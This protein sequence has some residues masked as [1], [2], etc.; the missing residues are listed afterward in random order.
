MTRFRSKAIGL[1]VTGFVAGTLGVA[2][3]QEKGEAPLHESS[4]EDEWA[5]R[6]SPGDVIQVKFFDNPELEDVIEIRPDGMV[7]MPLV[8][9]LSLADLT[10]T[11]ARLKLEGLYGGIVRQ[12]AVTVQVREY[13]SQKIYVGGEVLHPGVVALRGELTVLDAIM[14]AGGHKRT[15]TQKNVVLIREGPDGRPIRTKLSLHGT[16]SEAGAASVPLRPF[17]VVLVPES[18]I[19]RMDRWVDQYVRQLVPVS[20]TAGFTYLATGNTV[21]IP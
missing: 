14:E 1:L 3:A 12:P 5:F 13:A 4:G 2:L 6:L 11:E 9:E 20:L 10:I 17:D 7:S 19:A 15:A 21:V 18:R 16:D 8:G